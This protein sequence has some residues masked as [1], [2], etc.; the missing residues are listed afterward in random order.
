MFKLSF[1]RF[2][3]SPVYLKLKTTK[4]KILYP[5]VCSYS[6]YPVDVAV[7]INASLI[8]TCLLHLIIWISLNRWLTMFVGYPSKAKWTVLPKKL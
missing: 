7:G 3:G 5:S 2:E 4:M 1:I 6:L 8:E